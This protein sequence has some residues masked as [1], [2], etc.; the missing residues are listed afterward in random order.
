[1]NS[2]RLAKISL[3]AAI[4]LMVG[5]VIGFVVTLILNAFVL[6]KFNAYG[7]VPI[8]GSGTLHF[9]A[10]EVTVSFHTV[11]IGRVSGG[12]LPVPQLGVDVNPPSGVGGAEI[13]RKLWHL[14]ISQQRRTS[15]G[16][17]DE[18]S[19]RG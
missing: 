18:G 8:P 3:A 11:T 2:R 13:D 17:G 1:M 7:E 12:G 5:S 19:R 10:G 14:N 9:P 6:D 15:P 16:V 4:V